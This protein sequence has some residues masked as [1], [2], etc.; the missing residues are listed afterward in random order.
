[1]RGE[2]EEL[3]KPDFGWFHFFRTIIQNGTWAKMS[4]AAKAAYPVIKSYCN[5]ENGAAFPSYETLSAKSGLSRQSVT[6]ALDELSKLD[7]ITAK[8]AVGKATVYS[9]KETFEV[10]HPVSGRQGTASFDYVPQLVQKAVDEMKA[11]ITTGAQG[12]IIQINF[13][14]NCTGDINTHGVHI[15]GVSTV[16]G[17]DDILKMLEEKER[18]QVV[19]NF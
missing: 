19:D 7:L 12:K 5:S 15:E 17:A 8:K 9:L 18:L 4:L 16:N 11:L 1:M 14:L 2:Q 6:K 13:N 3:F 10:Q